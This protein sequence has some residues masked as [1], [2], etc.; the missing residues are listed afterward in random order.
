M[1]PIS[2]ANYSDSNNV[3]GNKGYSYDAYQFNSRGRQNNITEVGENN[4]SISAVSNSTHFDRGRVKEGIM[5]E[6]GYENC[7]YISQESVWNFWPTLIKDLNQKNNKNNYNNNNNNSTLLT[8]ELH[9]P[10]REPLQHLMSMASHFNKK[11]VCDEQEINITIPQA[12]DTVYM[13]Q[14][15]DSRFS[16]TLL[17]NNSDNNNNIDLKCFNPFPLENYIHYMKDKLTSRRFPVLHYQQRT[18]NQQ[19]EKSTECIW[20]STSFD[21]KQKVIQLLIE[22]HPYMKFCSDCIGSNNE[23]QLL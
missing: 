15:G 16:T 22:E 2:R 1:P 23:L 11:Y 14:F 20:D 6:I 8:L 5:K 17:L 3:C 18:T 12:I 13:K 4:D 19:H 21:Y 7:N 10:C 9:V